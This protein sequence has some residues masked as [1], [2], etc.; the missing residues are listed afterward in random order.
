[1]GVT[2]PE[3]YQQLLAQLF[4]LFAAREDGYAV[5]KPRPTDPSKFAYY[6]V[7]APFSLEVLDLHARGQHHV[8]VYP[9]REDRVKWAAID[10]DAPKA[11]KG[12]SDAFEA[13]WTE[14]VAQA[15]TFE[16]AGL[17]CYLERSRSGTGVHLWMFFQDWQSAATVR[18]ALVPLLLPGV[19]YDRIYPLQD[20]VDA[21]EYG[22][23]LALPFSGKAVKAGNSVF[24]T[25]DREPIDVWQWAES[26]EFADTAILA[27]LAAQHAPLER[28]KP[29]EPVAVEGGPSVSFGDATQDGRPA[30]PL[31]GWLKVQSPYGCGIMHYAWE[32]RRE[33]PEPLWYAVLQQASCFE[34][35]RELAHLLSRDY[36][37]YDPR[38]TNEKYNHALENP[39]IGCDSLRE[40]FPHLAC[41]GCPRLAP[42]HLAKRSLLDAVQNG[43]G[44]MQR[45]GFRAFRQQIE[46]YEAGRIDPGFGV[47][48]P[49][50]D[51][52]IRARRGEL[53]VF[54]A[55]PNTGKCVTADTTVVVPRTGERITIKE[56]IERGETEIHSLDRF[57]RQCVERVGGYYDGGVKPTVRIEVQDGR[58]VT[59][60][61]EHPLLTPRGWVKCADLEVGDS[62]AVPPHLTTPTLEPTLSDDELFIAACFIADGSVTTTT[63]VYTKADP[64]LVSRLTDAVQ[65]VGSELVPMDGSISSYLRRAPGRKDDPVKQLLSRLGITTHGSL[66]CIPAEVWKQPLEK[67]A[68]FLGVLWSGDGHVGERVAQFAS[69]SERLTRDVKHALTRLGISSYLRFGKN[70]GSGVW[71]VTLRDTTNLQRFVE[72]VPLHGN[73]AAQT[74]NLALPVRKAERRH[75]QRGDRYADVIDRIRDEHGSVPWDVQSSNGT[76]RVDKLAKLRS[77]TAQWL[78]TADVR[79][80]RVTQKVSAGE[81]QVY[82]LC[83]PATECFIAND[84]YVHNTAYMVDANV[85]V[86]RQG[87]PTF[88][89][90]GETMETGFRN[91]LIANVAGIDS[92]ALRGERLDPF[93]GG[94][95]RLSRDEWEAIDRA[96]EELDQL[97]I[98]VDYTA[99]QP[100]RILTAFERT[101]IEQ[102]IGFDQQAWISVDYLQ[103]SL[104]IDGET[105]EQRTSRVSMEFKALAKLTQQPLTVFSQ[106]VRAAETT[107]G[108]GKKTQTEA[109]TP[110]LTW[111]RGSG[112]IEQDA[113]VAL[114]LTGPRVSGLIAPRSLWVM[115]QRE[116]DVGVKVNFKFHKAFSRWQEAQHTHMAVEPCLLD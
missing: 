40:Q 23:A 14:A 1:M 43:E 47:G 84:I 62:I 60:T 70:S 45:G 6:K 26:V 30:I 12:S 98:N 76:L 82:D 3:A 102:G 56:F 93:T 49:T 29:A 94:M 22:N 44:K 95:Q 17:R 15:D 59:V 38:E 34:N 7:D 91:R 21:G 73:R 25:R 101:L 57:N 87:I 109:S 52:T 66:K 103:L 61:S 20:R 13:A 35:G 78:A 114:I 108:W 79:W 8:A 16:Q 74:A 100:D 67:L 11:L 106:L 32:H 5:G 107:N 99:T 46:A 50:L 42:Y 54:G 33:I 51:Q 97:P 64:V 113:D 90:S 81:Q 112:R 58:T 104:P 39:P 111:F 27:T 75:I 53:T 24:L 92:R 105:L 89:F 36:E 115:K 4:D 10:F 86:A 28:N 71:S 2:T 68:F 63:K 85:R 83:V 116:G 41:P 9:L 72:R 110:E 88:A 37:K 55:A 31:T 80:M 19:T 96:L 65:R 77:P 69:A 18:R 48:H